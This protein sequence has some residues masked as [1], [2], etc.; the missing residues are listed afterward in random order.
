MSTSFHLQLTERALHDYV[1]L[2]VPIKSSDSLAS[3]PSGTN[4]FLFF[5]TNSACVPGCWCL[6]WR[7]CVPDHRWNCLMHSGHVV[8]CVCKE[9][10]HCLQKHVCHCAEYNCCCC[11]H[12]QSD[13]STPCPCCANTSS[14]SATEG[15]VLAFTHRFQH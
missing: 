13:S 14:I 15:G 3:L 5:L 7:L 2:T 10:S 4:Y 6:C 9:T 1:I 12:R 11:R 8:V